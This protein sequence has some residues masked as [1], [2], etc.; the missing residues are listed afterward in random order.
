MYGKLV[1]LANIALTVQL[2]PEF[3]KNVGQIV[4]LSG[5]FTVNRKESSKKKKPIHFSHKFL[6]ADPH[7]LHL[8]EN[9]LSLKPKDLPT[10]DKVMAVNGQVPGPLFNATTNYN[11]VVRV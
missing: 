9:M 10:A 8:L 1:H 4:L 3:S 6:H 11:V 7:A 2:E 5:P